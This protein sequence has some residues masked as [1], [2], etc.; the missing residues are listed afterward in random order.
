MKYHPITRTKKFVKDHKVGIAVTVTALVALKLN[1][2]ALQDHEDFMQENGILDA[3]Y[4][5]TDAA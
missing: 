3:F 4:T 1:K 2:L 5:Q